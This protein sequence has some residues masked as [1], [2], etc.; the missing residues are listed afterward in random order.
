MQMFNIDKYKA[1]GGHS[2][3]GSVV[4]IL[5]EIRNDCPDLNEF[6][7]QL[8]DMYLLEAR[9]NGINQLGEDKKKFVQILR[10][11]VDAKSHFR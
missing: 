6:Q 3:S 8:V 2:F 10:N 7:K 9:L 5:Q 11:L 4:V 1:C